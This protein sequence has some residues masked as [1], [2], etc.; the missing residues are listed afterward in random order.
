LRAIAL[1]VVVGSVES[2]MFENWSQFV[3]PKLVILAF[4]V[5]LAFFIRYFFRKS[6]GYEALVRQNRVLALRAE[7]RR[8]KGVLFYVNTEKKIIGLAW[9]ADFESEL[10]LHFDRVMNGDAM[11]WEPIVLRP[12]RTF[13]FPEIGS[14]Y[15]PIHTGTPEQ[16]F[17]LK[18]QILKVFIGDTGPYQL[19]EEEVDTILSGVTTR[20]PR[21][22]VPYAG[23]PKEGE[24]QFRHYGYQT[25]DDFRKLLTEI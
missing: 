13:T 3:N 6:A 9:A 19:T 15:R 5:G 18:L 21:L 10:K 2:T 4:V 12:K 16:F 23:L 25:I 24:A 11:M 17:D 1:L 7:L 22:F 14:A 8:K 20:D